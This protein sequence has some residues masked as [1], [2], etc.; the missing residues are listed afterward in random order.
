VRPPLLARR[1]AQRVSQLH[2]DPVLLVT[3][4][5]PEVG[6]D[7]PNATAMVV[8]DAERFGISQLHQLRGRVGR[9]S[10]PGVCLL[11]TEAPPATPARNRLDALAATSDGFALSELDLEQRREGTILGEQQHGRSDLKLL[12]LLRDR[13]LIEQA[14]D[15]AADVVADDPELARRPALRAA[16]ERL[17][18]A[19]DV[20][21]LEKA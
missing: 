19:V 12:S 3:A 17:T 11:V 14:R 18:A 10:A 7:V 2:P 15:A 4:H 16:V 9:G 6:V 20:G 5:Q 21:Y 1:G 8:L 13:D